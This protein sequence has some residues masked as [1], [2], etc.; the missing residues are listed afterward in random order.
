MGVFDRV[1]G[2]QEEKPINFTQQEAFSAVCVLAV[3]A[4]GVIED[5]EV[6]R[7][8][9]T[10]AQKQ[11][12][13]KSRMDDVGQQLNRAA[14]LLQRGGQAQVIDAVKKA[15][16]ANLRESAFALAADLAMADGQV[17]AKEKAFLEEFYQA[18]QVQEAVAI[19][20]MEVMLIKNRG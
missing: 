19:K 14:N 11:L 13:R 6:R 12:F 18:L 9:T 2:K 17:D 10:L 7:I 1:L 4:D 3:A 15:L 20:I 16:P 5:D 8:V